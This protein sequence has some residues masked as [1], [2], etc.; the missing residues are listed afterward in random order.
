MR[1]D[2]VQRLTLYAPRSVDPTEATVLTPRAGSVHADGFK[3]A[4]KQG[5]A[6]FQPF[7]EVNPQGRDSQLDPLNKHLDIGRRVY[8]ILDKRIGN[9]NLERWMT[10]F[11]GDTNGGNQLLGLKAVAEQS[12]DGGATW[13]R[14]STDRVYAQRSSSGSLLW[15]E[16]DCRT[17]ADDLERDIFVGPP[18]ANVAAYAHMA[19]VAP[20]GLLK[21]YGDFPVTTAIKGKVA[22]VEPAGQR[23][24]QIIVDRDQPS[25]KKTIYTAAL[26]RVERHDAGQPGGRSFGRGKVWVQVVGSGV[27]KAHDFVR[28]ENYSVVTTAAGPTTLAPGT[29]SLTMITTRKLADDP[30]ALND[31][32]LFYIESLVEPVS[33][34]VPLLIDDVHPVTLLKHLC[35]GYYGRLTDAGAVSWAVPIDAASFAALEADVTIEKVRFPIQG[36]AKLRAWVEEYLLKPNHLSIRLNE[37]GEVVVVDHRRTSVFAPAWTIGNADCVAAKD[38]ISWEQ[39]KESAVAAVIGKYYAERMI[40]DS[41]LPEP[42][43]ALDN[44][45]PGAINSLNMPEIPTVRIEQ[46]E[47]P[48][49]VRRQSFSSRALD[50]G[51][52]EFTFDSKGLR[53]RVGSQASNGE[54]RNGRAREQILRDYLA[55]LTSELSGPFGLGPTYYTVRG[56][57]SSAQI[58]LAKVGTT[59]VLD[60]DAV[61]DPATGVR[62]GARVGLVISRIEQGPEV[63]LR[64]LD[65][66]ANAV[67]VAPTIGAPAA[68]VDQPTTA[69]TIA[70]TVNGTAQ[71]MRLDVAITSTAIGVRPL[72]SSELWK[73]AARAVATGTVTVAGLAGAG[74]RVWV[75]ARTEPQPGKGFALPS[76]WVYPNAGTGYVDLTALAPPTAPA[77]NSPAGDLIDFS[78]TLGAAHLPLEVFIVAGAAAPTGLE[79]ERAH[80]TLE[81]GSVSCQ[82]VGKTAAATQYTVGVRHVDAS[83][84]AS[85]MATVTLNTAAAAALVAPT[86]PDGFSSIRRAPYGLAV[87]AGV[88]PSQI[89]FAEAVETGVG[90]GVYGAYG[91]VG[92]L[93]AAYGNWTKWTGIA[94]QDG[95]RRKLKARTIRDNGATASAYTA[96]VIV[97]PWTINDPIVEYPI[98][99]PTAY[100]EPVLGARTRTQ[101]TIRF[102]FVI[103]ANDT[104]PAS[105]RYSVDGGA[106]SGAAATA[107]PQDVAFTRSKFYDKKGTLEITQADG[108][109]AYAEFVIPAELEALDETTGRKRRSVPQD[110]GDY[111]LRGTTSNGFTGH[112]SITESGGRRIARL[113][114]KALDAD[115]DT[116]DGTPEGTTFKR[117]HNTA[118]NVSGQVDF[119]KSG[120]ANKNL[121]YIADTSEYFRTPL[122]GANANNA[123]DNGNFE[124]STTIPP[125]GWTANGATLSY[126]TASQ[127][128]G[129]R[130]LKVVTAVQSGGAAQIRRIPIVPGERWRVSGRIKTNGACDGYI[131]VLFL[132]KDG[133]YLFDAVAISGSAVWTYAE[134]TETVPINA[135]Y[136]FIYVG[137]TTVGGGTVWFDEIEARRVAE[138]DRD[139]RRSSSNSTP[140]ATVCGQITDAGHAGSGMQESGGKGLNRLYA[141]ALTSDPD[142]IDSVAQGT[143]FGRVSRAYTDDSGRTHTLRRG[144]SGD[145]TAENV[146]ASIGADVENMVANG[147]GQEGSTGG[148]ATGWTLGSGYALLPTANGFPKI[149]DRCLALNNQT[150]ANSYSYQDFTVFGD[151][152]YELSAWIKV[153]SLAGSGNTDG[154]LL[155]VDVSVGVTVIEK[156]GDDFA[157]AEADVGVRRSNGATQDWRF[158]RCVFRTNAGATA[159]RLYLQLGY[160]GTLTGIAYFDGVKLRRVPRE[161]NEGGRRGFRGFANDLA[162][163]VSG[164][165]ESAGKAVNR[166][167]AKSLNSDPDNADSV[168]AGSVRRVPLVGGTDASGNIDLSGSAW[169]NKSLDYLPDGAAYI[170]ATDFAA[171]INVDN[172]NFEASTAL[173]PPGWTNDGVTLSYL[174][175]GNQY[176]GNRSLRVVSTFQYGG[177]THKRRFRV[178]PGERIRITARVKTVGGAL[179]YL[180]FGFL[181]AAGTWLGGAQA[182][183]ASAAWTEVTATETAPAGTV[184][185]YLTFQA[186]GVGGGTVDIDEVRVVR[187]LNA[188]SEMRRSSANDTTIGV[189]VDRLTDAG[190]AAST[191]QESGGKAINR[192]LGK[193][194]SSDPD[195]ADSVANGASKRA[196]P[197]TCIRSTDDAIVTR[198]APEAYIGGGIEQADAVAS[199]MGIFFSEVF[200]QTPTDAG[201]INEGGNPAESLV[202]ANGLSSVG[203][204]VLSVSGS[205]FWKSHPRVFAFN[206]SKLY[207]LRVRLRRHTAGTGGN[208]AYI[209]LRCF[210]A[211]SSAANSNGGW[212]Y[213]TAS[214]YTVP[215]TWTELTAWVKGATLAYASGSPGVSTDPR[216]PTAL[217]VDTVVVRP[218]IALNYSDGT[219]GYY[220]DYY[221]I[222]ELDEDAEQRVYEVIQ[223][224][225]ATLYGTVKES[226]AKAVNRLLAKSLAA[227]PDN[228]DGV[229]NGTTY[230]RVVGVDINGKVP[231]S[232]LVTNVTLSIDAPFADTVNAELD[233]S[234][235]LSNPP[236]GTITYTVSYVSVHQSGAGSRGSVSGYSSTSKTF[237]GVS[238]GSTP[239]GEVYVDAFCNGVLIATAKS[240]GA[241]AV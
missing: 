31:N 151:E 23:T 128:S 131:Q 177:T 71:E 133:N 98:K 63:R 176:S 105:W 3:V 224:D 104:G 191:M 185:G 130:S 90:T 45:L 111:D 12:L 86:N 61:P 121:S 211:D 20:I 24:M 88:L 69:L 237:T 207:R 187:L 41:E 161:V 64:I 75:R 193:P 76:A 228:L 57:R 32:V 167:L 180:K 72:D 120:F 171:E 233:V 81:Q 134:D 148:Q 70:A 58:A 146:A 166:L 49:V 183:T 59:G 226:G 89:E 93:E 80:D 217:N 144:A 194:L 199:R 65:W 240:F 170:R 109:K 229:A 142:N 83:G 106:F 241:F 206:P 156:I 126:E 181:D 154:A 10:A 175:G 116:L 213:V 218:L 19:Q 137:T 95:K 168:L 160:G 101:E 56:L 114:A 42:F 1:V 103:G 163:L 67:A 92:V 157:T 110:D 11:L 79:T 165:T 4:T 129:S 220:V 26:M 7:L 200:N 94:P 140:I 239:E 182:G 153:E 33:K 55:G 39:D 192:L 203:R 16:L 85:A 2:V 135:V 91:S 77:A 232:S 127:Y 99:A 169:T 60:H 214:A 27:W 29:T 197:Y 78:W 223:S 36:K 84:N 172:A 15:I 186:Q 18:H 47:E 35:L 150:L 17:M 62:G 234:W 119:S 50:I 5:I 74:K 40:A 178:A 189:I 230:K 198:V 22:S 210:R 209:G 6:G 108:Q 46:L 141:K 53:F 219:H 136:G 212:A 37:F 44:L 100:A 236:S 164:A 34:E 66:G 117:T 225:K 124:A 118:L 96:E 221:Q 52:S 115:P 38:A 68:S 204:K 97:A 205:S 14:Y 238:F 174:T 208:V 162:A 149:G 25:P 201:W 195:T 107:S 43:T 102:T 158:V 152:V 184:S 28:G 123:V 147:G 125:V 145:V 8:R 143:A 216:S 21:P 122:F 155:N 13:N 87:I 222:E 173:P 51:G 54:Q 30:P 196:I 139:V 112:T 48:Y 82:I 159:L 190:H 227:D 73:P 138:G 132:D 113:L 179:G 235:T 202:E 188:D 9:S 215:D 231:L